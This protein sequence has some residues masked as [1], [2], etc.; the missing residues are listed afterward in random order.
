MGNR[1]TI[2]SVALVIMA[3]WA[4]AGT[5]FGAEAIPAPGSKLSPAGENKV[6]TESDVTAERVGDSIP[7]SAIGEPVSAGQTL[8]SAMGGRG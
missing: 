1:I 4:I 6:I 7:V 2:V 8:C 5:S 3:L